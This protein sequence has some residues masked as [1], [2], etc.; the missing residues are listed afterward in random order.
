MLCYVKCLVYHKSVNLHD[1]FIVNW[2]EGR[3]IFSRSRW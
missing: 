3:T 2:R 1:V